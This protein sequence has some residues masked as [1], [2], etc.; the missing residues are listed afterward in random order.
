[1]QLAAYLLTLAAMAAF[2]NAMAI[3]NPAIQAVSGDYPAEADSGNFSIPFVTHQE[4]LGDT[5]DRLQGAKRE[6][7]NPE[8]QAVEGAYGVARGRSGHP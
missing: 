6:V 7:Y 3:T 1:M 4:K 2:T 8:P 5:T